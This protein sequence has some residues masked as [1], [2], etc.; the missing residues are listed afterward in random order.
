M[1][2]SGIFFHQVWPRINWFWRLLR[3]D[4]I[5]HGI[6]ELIRDRHVLI[7]GT[8]TSLDLELLSEGVFDTSIGLH[9]VHH[10][11]GSVSWRPDLLLFGD[12]A[13]LMKQGAEICRAQEE[14]ILVATGS[15]FWV[16]SSVASET[17]LSFLD[18]NHGADICFTGDIVAK[19]RRGEYTLGR[20]VICL[21]LQICARYSAKSITI[22]GVDFDYAAGYISNEITNSGINAPV[23]DVAKRQ[24]SELLRVCQ[25]ELRI[26]IKHV[27]KRPFPTDDCKGVLY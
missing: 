4:A 25:E 7:V 6:E 21:A 23:P 1:N 17:R 8:G 14:G 5:D 11:Y 9:R 18:L 16:P 10:V 15:R 19:C 26:P 20:S 24:F 22:T 12:E 3:S 13:L 27:K 2:L